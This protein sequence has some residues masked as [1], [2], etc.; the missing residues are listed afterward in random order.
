[1][2]AIALIV[3]IA[4]A[5]VN[6]LITKKAMSNDGKINKVMVAFALRMVICITFIIA[7]VLI[8]RATNTDMLLPVVGIGLGISIPS[9]I[10]SF[11]L[12]G[13]K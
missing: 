12:S 3:G 6:Y 2:T 4:V 10:F 7:I 11:L 9:I 8:C 1:M 13:K 5:A